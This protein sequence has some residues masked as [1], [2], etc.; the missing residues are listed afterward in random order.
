MNNYNFT[1]TDT[2][3]GELNYCWVKKFSVS[4]KSDRAAI[5]AASKHFGL[6]GLLNYQGNDLWKI[7]GACMALYSE[8]D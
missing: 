4:A 2:F 7:T 6:Q 5:R 3:S 1:L 8:Y